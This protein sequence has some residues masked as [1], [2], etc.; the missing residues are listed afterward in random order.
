M[1]AAKENRIEIRSSDEEKREFE[2]AAALAHMG[3]SEFIRFAAHLYAKSIRQEH[4]NISLS[5]Q[6]ASSFLE[7][8]ESPP[9]PNKRLKEALSRHEKNLEKDAP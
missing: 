4:Q 7:A 9:Q 2:E 1:A 6:E 8:L 3:L 5:R